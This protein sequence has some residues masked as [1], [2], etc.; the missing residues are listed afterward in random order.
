MYI[1]KILFTK[2]YRNK[3][4]ALEEL[5][6]EK[7]CAKDTTAN[8]KCLIK[9]RAVGLNFEV[10]KWLEKQMKSIGV[11]NSLIQNSQD[12]SPIKPSDVEVAYNFVH[13]FKEKLI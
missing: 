7:Q 12:G 2:F 1:E 4:K 8:Q 6:Y 11:C 3:Q 10:T 13:D 9:I 5:G